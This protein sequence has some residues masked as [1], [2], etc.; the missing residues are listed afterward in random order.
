MNN[1]QFIE[2]WL[3][4]K[5]S[6]ELWLDVNQDLNKMKARGC[7]IQFFIILILSWLFA[8]IILMIDKILR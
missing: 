1:K 3:Q 8:G 2:K 4:F 6:G 7:I 5:E